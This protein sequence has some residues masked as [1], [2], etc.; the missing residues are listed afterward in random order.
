MAQ[1]YMIPLYYILFLII[2]LGI[3]YFFIYDSEDVLREND[4]DQGTRE[5]R[6]DKGD[7]L[8]HILVAIFWFLHFVTG[9]FLV[10]DTD[11]SGVDDFLIWM[12]NVHGFFYPMAVFSALLFFKWVRHARFKKY[13]WDWLSSLGGYMGGD[14]ELPSGHFNGGQKLW[15]WFLPLFVI[16]MSYTGHELSEFD[17]NDP[18]KF[19]WLL[20]HM[21]G[22]GEFIAMI[23]IHLYIVLFLRPVTLSVMRDGKISKEYLEK[24]H[25]KIK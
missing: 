23:S 18:S 2:V 21:V 17:P 6:W 13:D 16:F 1:I 9:L 12:M 20:A 10:F 25:S 8:L 5:K 14:K 22:A 11:R 4:F 3:H 24:F 7:R 15:L 19:A